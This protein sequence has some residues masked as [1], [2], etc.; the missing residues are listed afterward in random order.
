MR[1]RHFL[2][3]LV[4]RTPD[5]RVNRNYRLRRFS[6]TIIIFLSDV[7][8]VFYFSNV[9]NIIDGGFLYILVC[10]ADL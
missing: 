5:Q 10:T 4:K 1:R 2:L 7:I 3:L 8:D 6:R 9:F